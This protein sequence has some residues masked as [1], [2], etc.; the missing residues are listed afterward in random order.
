MRFNGFNVVE[1]SNTPGAR[2]GSFYKIQKTKTMLERQKR[3]LATGNATQS[4]Y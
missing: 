2:N 3:L 1:V 4:H